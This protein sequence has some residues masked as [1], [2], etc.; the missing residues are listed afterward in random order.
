MEPHGT[1]DGWYIGRG[2]RG[3]VGTSG[4]PGCGGGGGGGAF[5]LPNQ[6]GGGGGQGGGGGCGGQG[7]TG[8]HDGGASIGMF[9]SNVSNI[10]LDNV[11]IRTGKGGEGGAGG[12]GGFGGPGGAGGGGGSCGGGWVVGRGGGGAGGTWAARA[13]A[14]WRDAA[15]G[16]WGMVCVNSQPI[17]NELEF[18]I[19]EAGEALGTADVGKQYRTLGCE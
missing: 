8:G 17:S 10:V 14:A 2:E 1:P 16:L 3:G 19:G 13:A 6:R 5:W 12:S 15:V 9:L 18:F 11:F 7:G 4:T